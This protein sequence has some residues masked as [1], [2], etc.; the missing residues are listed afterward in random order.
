MFKVV[1]D[2]QYM[3]TPPYRTKGTMLGGLANFDNNS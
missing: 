2:D 1:T 3:L